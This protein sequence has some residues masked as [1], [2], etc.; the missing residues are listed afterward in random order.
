MSQRVVRA[1]VAVL[2]NTHRAKD[3]FILAVQFLSRLWGGMYAPVFPASPSPSD[4]LTWM[5]GQYTAFLRNQKAW[6]NTKLRQFY[7]SPPPEIRPD[8]ECI[9]VAPP[10]Q[11]T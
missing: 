11:E 6:I 1:R 7:D 9:A 3:D 2:I 5:A 10:G 4:P 8:L